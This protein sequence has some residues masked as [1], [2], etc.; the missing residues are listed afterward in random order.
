[1]FVATST[2]VQRG[3]ASLLSSAAR[4]LPAVLSVPTI[5]TVPT[6]CTVPTVPSVP[7]T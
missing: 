3:A 5:P 6:S 4:Y 2:S 7:N 1:M